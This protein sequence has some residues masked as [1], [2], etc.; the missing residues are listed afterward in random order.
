MLTSLKT[1]HGDLSLPAFLP[2]ATRGVVRCV[3][4]DD[5]RQ[6]G[7]DALMVNTL[8]L[9]SQPGVS[10]VKAA[11]G[12]HRFAGWDGPI[13]SDSGGFQV[14]SLA[15]GGPK[16]VTVSAKGLS[17]KPEGR[18][19]R[20]Q[21]TPE[22]CIQYQ[23]QLGA[24]ILFCLDH[25]PPANA[26]EA[27]HRES[28]A[29]TVAWA[30]QCKDA[31]GKRYSISDGF[32]RRPPTADCPRPSLFAVVQGGPHPSLRT[33]CAERLLEIGFDGF[34]FGGWPI[35]EDGGLLEAVGQLAELL[36]DDLPLHGLGIGKPENVLAAWRLGYHTFDC[37]LPTRDARQGRL[38]QSTSETFTGDYVYL[39][40]EKER[41]SRDHSPID[42]GCD[43]ATC[44]RYS[45]AYLHHLFEI[46]EP[47][48]ARLA[49]I[50]N[51]RFYGRLMKKLRGEPGG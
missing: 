49:T 27:A 10:V 21:L 6:A 38:Y 22:K 39:H 33:E 12:I 23:V 32:D 35:A 41:F 37:T 45:R 36:P 51:L 46:G 40:V 24:D 25:C 8:H 26:D 3:D 11:G 17:Y 18:S 30:R 1:A 9:S 4:V 5:V 34:G 31:L 13:A 15:A 19:K 16:G 47:A 2:D 48:G 50:H 20:R 44:G 7:I 42:E 14:L 43:C 29:H 28:V